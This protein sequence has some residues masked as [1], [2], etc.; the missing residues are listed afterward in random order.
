LE[1]WS[2]AYYEIVNRYENT[3]AAQFFGHTHFDQ[4]KIYYDLVNTSRAVNIAY[5]TPSVTTYSDLNPAYR[6]Y[7]IDGFY[8]GTS[9]RVLDHETRILN[10]TDA[11]L[12]NKPKWQNGYSAKVL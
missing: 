5:I 3:I 1:S 12:T 7:T 4:F 2:R 11:N 8:E 10:L 6:I 9:A